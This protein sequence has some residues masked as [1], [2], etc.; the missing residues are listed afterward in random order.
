MK[1][2]YAFVFLLMIAAPLIPSSGETAVSDREAARLKAELTPPALRAALALAEI[3]FGRQDPAG[4]PVIDP[5]H[6]RFFLSG[7]MGAWR[8]WRDGLTTDQAEAVDLLLRY[9]PRRLA[10]HRADTRLGTDSSP[11]GAFEC[12]PNA[13]PRNRRSP[14]PPGPVRFP[15]RHPIRPIHMFAVRAVAGW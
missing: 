5:R 3:H 6:A 9:R 12:P 15:Q 4:T 8:R 11:V 2:R 14:T 10:I 7:Q 1:I 13:V